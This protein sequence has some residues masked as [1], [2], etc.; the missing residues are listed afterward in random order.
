MLAADLNRMSVKERNNLME[1]LHGV[2][3]E[4]EETP[5]FLAERLNRM[6]IELQRVANELYLRAVRLNPDYI[7]GRKFCLMFLRAASYDPAK[8]AVRMIKF[9]K[10]KYAYFGGDALARPLYLSDLDKEEMKVLKSGLHQVFSSRTMAGKVVVGTFLRH[11]QSF[12]KQPSLFVSL[13]ALSSCVA[14]RRTL[15]LSRA[16]NRRSK[17]SFLSFVL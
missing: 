11:T 13:I 2:E 15:T 5:E 3:E 8:A 7:K 4:I 16:L 10:E 14:R 12:A 9:L 1:E 6:E 17:L